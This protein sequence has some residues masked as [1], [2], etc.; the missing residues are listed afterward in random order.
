MTRPSV[1]KHACNL[2]IAGL[3]VPACQHAYA[4]AAETNGQS[5]VA[6]DTSDLA[7]LSLEELGNI[8]VTSVSRKAEPLSDAAASIYVITRDD[9][10]RSG[11]TSLAEALRLAPNLEVAQVNASTYAISARGFNSNGANKLLVL[12]DGRT[13]YS[14]LFSGVFWDVQDL[15]L[16]DVE[17]IE[18]V[19]G[20]GG[21]LWG[22]NAVNGVINVI[23]RSAQDTHGGLL[24]SGIGNGE[25][26]SAV[27]YGG[28]TDGGIN[29]RV[30]AKTFDRDHTVTANGGPVDDGWHQ[31]QAGFRADWSRPGDRVTIQ[32]DAYYGAEAQPA[33]G[34][35]E[36]SGVNI[37]RGPVLTSGENLTAHWDHILEG[38]SQLN[39]LSYLDR[40]SRNVDPTYADTLDIFDVQIMQSFAPLG[41]HN[42]NWGAEYRRGDDNVVSG[43]YFAFLP[44]NLKQ[45][46]ASLFAQDEMALTP[47]LK[48]TGG[49]RLERNDYT[50]NEFLPNLRLA[51]KTSDTGL[52]WSALSRTVRAP[53]R[54]DRDAYV[55]ASPPFQLAG[56]PQFISEVARVFEIGYRGQVT[57]SLTY[58]ATMYYS[59]YDHLRSATLGPSG[60]NVV[61][62]NGME[63]RTEGVEMWGNYQA[64]PIWRLSAGFSALRENLQFYPNSGL[65]F[66]Q[67]YQGSDPAQWW[68]LRS[69]FDLPA[70][71]ELDVT[72]RH[73]A[74]LSNPVV[75][76]YSVASAR[77]GWNPRRNLEFSVVAQ[78]LIGSAHGEFSDVAY[79]TEFERSVFVKFV[80][81]F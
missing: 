19:S 56:G 50:G 24:T 46:W 9:I 23:T 62:A 58:S 64:A 57:G 14:P 40:T 47:T 4:L 66:P 33:P 18:V 42:A 44:A 2:L 16:E 15:I 65:Q 43:R 55:P 22:V 35:I 31:S 78:N 3:I 6:D 45:T 60:R 51:W 11:A 73:V 52:L 77:L 72:V 36:V 41:T 76:A 34:D 67:I 39:V 7:R 12:I 74:A 38:G 13:V 26:G 1:L 79:R 5:A 20:P 21:T 48:L 53:S 37:P 28:A 68:S 54:L 81:R 32:G 71:T 80:G 8:I 75:P 61:L 59:D 25:Q 49:V 63:G 10:R 17:R 30:Y 70:Q 27:R 29:Y 69:S